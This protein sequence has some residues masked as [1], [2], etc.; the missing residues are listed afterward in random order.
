MRVSFQGHKII[1][2]IS[3]VRRFQRKV[4][5]ILPSLFLSDCIVHVDLATVQKFVKHV[6]DVTCHGQIWRHIPRKPCHLAV[7]TAL[8]MEI[9]SQSV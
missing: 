3:P 1:S 7:N 5:T 9:R 8:L 6:N 4:D 2:L